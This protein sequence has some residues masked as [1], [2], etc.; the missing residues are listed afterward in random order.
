[1][2]RLQSVLIAC[3][4]CGEFDFS[5]G[6]PPTPETKTVFLARYGQRLQS[7]STA[8]FHYLELFQIRRR[9]VLPDVGYIDF[10]RNDYREMFVG[11]GYTFYDGKHV[12]LIEEMFFVQA[13]G[14]AANQARY[15]MPW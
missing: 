6:A 14:S 12:T 15:L 3:L 11:G 2:L 4:V 1:M 7:P 9:W 13:S 8:T 10:G 5:Q